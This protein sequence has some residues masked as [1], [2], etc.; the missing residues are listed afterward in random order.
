[1]PELKPEPLDNKVR[2]GIFITV[3]FTLAVAVDEFAPL[4]LDTF[5][6]TAAINEFAPV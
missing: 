6:D 2:F 3:M 1:V 5:N 4:L